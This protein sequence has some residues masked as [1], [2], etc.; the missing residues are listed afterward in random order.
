[1][2]LGVLPIKVETGCCK[3]VPVDKR[4]CESC[5]EVEDEMDFLLHCNYHGHLRQDLFEKAKRKSVGF[6]NLPDVEEVRTLFS[7]MWKDMC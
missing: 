6:H 3:N 5:G 4:L 7:H 2:R 1:M